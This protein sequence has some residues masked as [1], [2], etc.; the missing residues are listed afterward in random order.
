MQLGVKE[1]L[2]VMDRSSSLFNI[3][4][5]SY[6][7]FHNPYVFIIFHSFFIHDKLKS[8]TE[9]AVTDFALVKLNIVSTLSLLW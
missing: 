7:I 3:S 5:R 1:N 6:L 2:V 4:L 8:H 9:W